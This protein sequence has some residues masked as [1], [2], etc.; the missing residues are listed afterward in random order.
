MTKMS[1]AAHRL[2]AKR[3][4]KLKA[5]GRY[6]DGYGLYFQITESGSRSWLYRYERDKRERMMGLGPARLYSLKEARRLRDEAEKRLR[7]GDDPLDAKREKRRAVAKAHTFKEAALQYVVNKGAGWSTVHR[8]QWHQTLRDYA[9]PIIGELPVA[10]IDTEQVMRVLQPIWTSKQTAQRLRGRIEAVLGWATTMK[11]RS[12]D[13][14]ARWVKHLENLLSEPSKV[15]P[16]KHHAAMPYKALPAFMEELRAVESVPAR[17]LEVAILTAL[18]TGEVIGA[19]WSEI[20][21]TKREWVI[22]A[23]RMK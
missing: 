2:T 12:G 10:S 13:N 5:P 11:L 20:D 7:A 14:P 18:R 8:N 15:H 17:A 23:E 6:H 3:I 1:K 9:F 21:L 19:E 22:P 16:V 4:E